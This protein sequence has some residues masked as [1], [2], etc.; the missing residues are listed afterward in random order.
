MG[1]GARVLVV[2]LDGATW[3]LADRFI[4]EGAMPTLA[5]LVKGGLRA[6]LNSTTPPMTLPS[7]C[8][9]LT[10]CNPG[11]HGIFDFVT[12]EEGGLGLE[13]T[14]AT[15]RGVP[16]VHRVLSDRGA[17][18]A[19]VA[20]PT[21]WP[22]DPLHGV[23]I[24][25]FDSPVATGIDG[26]FVHP[27]GLHGELRRRFGDLR[28]ADFQ[29]S[30]IGPG[31]HDDALSALLREIPRKEAISRHLLAQ[32]RWDLFM[33]LFGES[34]TVSHHFWMFHDER[35][36]R[37]PEKVPPRLAGAIRSVYTRLDAA[38]GRLL[39]E[40]QPDVLCVC[41]D[42]GFGGAGVHV[43]HLNRF[44]E[45]AG[46][47]RYRR[48]V[49]VEGLRSGSSWFDAAKAAAVAHVPAGLQ[50]RLF[51]AL[52]ARWVGQREG[53]SRYADLDL[54]G[55]QA[56]S[57]EMNYAATVRLQ[58]SPAERAALAQTLA[59]ALLGWEV[60]GQRVVTAVHRREALY[61]GPFVGRS[62]DLVLDL[63]LRDGYSY[64]LLPSGRA[65]PGQT[66][67]R[68]RPEEHMGGKGL[69]MNGSHR[70]H[71]LLLLHGV[72]VP[73]GRCAAGMAD[74]APSLLALLGED[75]PAHMDGVVIP[76]LGRKVGRSRSEQATGARHVASAAER[77]A[78]RDRLE[79][80]GYL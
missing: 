15:H 49:A 50:G 34:D 42:H 80:L 1:R 4:A 22:P 58:G 69:G 60:D 79:R 66:F 13:F 64:T 3:D 32:E 30:H 43:L 72:G 51:R 39:E 57:D 16:T 28:F 47:L 59:E 48:Q 5:A 12:K 24:A 67:R 7:W 18:V 8:S 62:P 70:Q 20:V 9:M 52:P 46:L 73:A 29:E 76:E 11:R 17:R 6:P 40:A 19:S 54:A 63:A 27:P 25:G 78:L 31:W 35:S 23:V 38:L 37:R 65:A 53:E 71:G 21:T 75:V 26:S 41:S 2:G 45:E 56:F 14:N 74:I 44:L 68:L 55:T 33:V 61:E 77:G 36:P 10:G